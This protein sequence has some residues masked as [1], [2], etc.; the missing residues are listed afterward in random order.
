MLA[1][2]LTTPCGFRIT[3]NFCVLGVPQS[4]VAHIAPWR[5]AHGLALAYL[6]LIAIPDSAPWLVRYPARAVVTLGQNSLSVFCVGSLVGLLSAIALTEFGTGWR[7]Q[8][9]LNTAGTAL[10]FATARWGNRRGHFELRH[11]VAWYGIALREVLALLVVRFGL[12]FY[13]LTQRSDRLR[14]RRRL[15]I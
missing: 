11:A 7:S 15:V 2:A 13:A 6:A 1:F 3:A 12:S 10:L 14:G 4:D 5:I 8:L 9:L